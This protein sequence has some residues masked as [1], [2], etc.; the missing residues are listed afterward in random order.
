MTRPLTLSA[1]PSGTRIDLRVIPRSPR[2]KIDGVRDG[3]LLVRVSAPPVDDEA[4]E[5]VIL[6]LSRLLDVPRRDL[7]IV[8]GATGRNKTVEVSG[9]DSATVLSRLAV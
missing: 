9:L 6:E 2:S 5:A 1:T 8:S 4:N 7:R 3:R